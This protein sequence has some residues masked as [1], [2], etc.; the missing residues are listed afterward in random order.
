M[1]LKYIFISFIIIVVPLT[2][3]AAVCPP[4][5]VCNPLK[6]DT[7]PAL[8]NAVLGWIL[9][10]ASPVAVIMMIWSAAMF[11]TAAGNETRIKK[12]KE[13]L[14]WTLVAIFILMISY[15]ISTT[16]ANFLSG[17]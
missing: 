13:T 7:F 5:T 14:W 6:Y 8:L 11:M 17:T 12:A 2:I 3:F 15:G 4:L 9:A 16:I 1:N 10:L